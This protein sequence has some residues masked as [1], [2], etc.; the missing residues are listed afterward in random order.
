MSY[1]PERRPIL[2]AWAGGEFQFGICQSRGR[3]SFAARICL[4]RTV[5]EPTPSPAPAP[6][7]EISD[8]EEQRERH[9]LARTR[10]AG[11]AW[12]Q[13]TNHA[14]WSIRSRDGIELVGYYF[15]SP[16]KSRKCVLLVHG[17]N[18]VPGYGHHCRSIS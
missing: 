7:A 18:E 2:K 1:Y 15:P 8:A 10:R 16:R 14:Q 5:C 12:M 17:H 6:A 11:A 13:E 9:L 4:S 3:C